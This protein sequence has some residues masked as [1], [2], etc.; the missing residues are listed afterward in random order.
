MQSNVGQSFSAIGDV[1]VAGKYRVGR[2]IGSGSFGDI[3]FGMFALVFV[4]PRS[5]TNLFALFVLLENQA[6][7]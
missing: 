5:A 2:K 1:R 3:F 6:P 4:F 7:M